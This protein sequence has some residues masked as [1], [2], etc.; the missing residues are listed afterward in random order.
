[1]RTLLNSLFASLRA[2]QREEPLERPPRRVWWLIG[3]QALLAIG[4]IAASTRIGGAA[5][6]A[7]S[8]AMLLAAL[9]FL[10]TGLIAAAATRTGE[11]SNHSFNVTAVIVVSCAAATGLW[12]GILVTLVLGIG[13][14]LPE[15]RVLRLEHWVMNLLDDVLVPAS[16]F[17]AWTTLHAWSGNW[18]VAAFGA[19]LLQ[20]IVNFGVFLACARLER[21]PAGAAELLETLPQQLF[22]QLDSLLVAMTVAAHARNEWLALGLIVPPLLDA[23]AAAERRRAL[24][25][26]QNLQ[27]ARAELMTDNLT[28]LYTRGRFWAQLEE[29]IGALHERGATPSL[30]MCDI[31]NFKMLNDT[32]GHV[33]GDRALIGT[34]DALRAVADTYG[35]RAS[36][37]RYGGEEMSAI[38]LDATADELL[39]FGERLR[40]AAFEALTPWG[41]SLSLGVGTFE[42]DPDAH[43][44]V[45]RVDRALYGAKRGGKNRVEAARPL[46]AD[47]A[48]LAAHAADD[49]PR[50]A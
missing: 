28:G 18:F 8:A 27:R 39:A 21:G 29:R 47:Q 33:E 35:G 6:A 19:M 22:S 2:H 45:E 50:A 31:D 9:P 40:L 43:A 17:L 24:V 48:D 10:I 1:M 15:R 37:Y 32:H 49:Q 11:G 4:L 30:V 3:G 20:S 5:A 14:Y 7:P 46:V 34:A 25:S 26:E 16:A 13:S 36:V 38:L 42:G 41:T 44:F 23:L 12:C